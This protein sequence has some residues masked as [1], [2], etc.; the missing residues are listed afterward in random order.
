MSSTKRKHESLEDMTNTVENASAPQQDG[1]VVKKVAA[2]NPFRRFMKHLEEFRQKFECAAMVQGLL[3]SSSNDDESDDED[4]DD[5]DYLEMM[6]EDE[7][8]KVTQ[9]QLDN[10]RFVMITKNRAN[11]ILFF[12]KKLLGDQADSCLLMFDTSFGN[13]V[14]Q[15]YQ[16]WKRRFNK[17]KDWTQKFDLIF[18]LT[19][20]L[21]EFDTWMV[22]N[23]EGEGMNQLVKDLAGAWKRVLRKTDAELGIDSEFTRPGI[24]CFL[25]KFKRSV[26]SAYSE[27]P[28]RF[29]FE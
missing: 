15:Y 17:G 26:E 24:V 6:K 25:N 1:P 19:W 13:T 12:R 14:Y 18:S 5:E 7:A 29:R 20:N 28:Y 27:P 2:A 4:D 9:Q 23:E 8:A 11:L 21:N 16:T 22:D 3:R 10:V